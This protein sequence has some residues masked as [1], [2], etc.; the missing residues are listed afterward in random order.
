MNMKR[1]FLISIFFFAAF[2]VFVPGVQAET[3]LTP[4]Q[5]VKVMNLSIPWV[6]NQGQISDP[7]V[8]FSANTLLGTVFVTK[9]G[10]ITYSLVET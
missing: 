2:F 6:E 4:D 7:S 5:E 8:R 10:A 3:S 9:D 1:I